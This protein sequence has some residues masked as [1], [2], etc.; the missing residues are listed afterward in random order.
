MRTRWMAAALLALTACGFTYDFGQLGHGLSERDGVL[1]KDDVALRSQRW[2]A[3]A[4]PADTAALTL[5]SPT[6]DITLAAGPTSLEVLLCTEVEGDGSVALDGDHPV[7]TSAA[8]HAVALN[9]VRGTIGP[10]IALH[11][12]SGTGAVKLDG[13]HGS[14]AI[15]VRAGTGDVA[16]GGCTLDSVGVTC[17]TGR[18]ELTDTS[19][20]ALQAECGTGDVRMRGSHLKAGHIQSGTGD[21]ILSGHSDL[22]SATT[23]LG[24]GR[25]RSAD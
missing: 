10:T 9:G 17:G 7:A 20:D 25:V 5:A 18:L 6:G 22:G 14:P 11:L 1:Y 4:V 24:T 12:E 16:L 2:V 19:V 3:V 23:K 15:D 21:V 8:G 13:L